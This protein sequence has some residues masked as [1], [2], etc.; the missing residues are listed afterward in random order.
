MHPAGAGRKGQEF[1]LHPWRDQSALD[2]DR[3]VQVWPTAFA[4]PAEGTSQTLFHAIEHPET[5]SLFD[6]EIGEVQTFVDVP[7]IAPN[8]MAVGPDSVWVLDYDGTL[9]RI[10][11]R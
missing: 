2:P 4:G 1:V 9:T 5:V 7:G 11:L 8:A 3:P 6:P 10:E